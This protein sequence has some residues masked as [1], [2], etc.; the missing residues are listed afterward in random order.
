[1]DYRSGVG[2]ITPATAGTPGICRSQ[3]ATHPR[4]PPPLDFQKHAQSHLLNRINKAY[5]R[6]CQ[7]ENQ[8]NFLQIREPRVLFPPF[9]FTFAVQ[10]LNSS[11]ICWTLPSDVFS[12]PP[13]Y[14]SPS[15]LLSI[16]RLLRLDRTASFKRLGT[17]TFPT[18]VRQRHGPRFC[19]G[20]S[21]RLR[22]RPSGFKLR[23]LGHRRSRLPPGPHR[24]SAIRRRLRESRRHRH[25]AQRVGPRPHPSPKSR[26]T[27]TQN[28]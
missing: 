2:T 20:P 23:R 4:K 14:R 16:R 19:D 11:P 13:L 6:P 1:M 8:L 3:K 7:A 5:P 9:T 27:R 24:R 21:G 28:V 15:N 26:K 18:I 12:I 25:A 10:R 17:S 22:A